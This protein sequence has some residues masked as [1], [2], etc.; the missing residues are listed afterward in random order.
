VADWDERYRRG[1]H[2]PHEPNPLLV[3]A[4]HNLAPGRA[5]DIACGAGR[6]ALFLA[7]QGWRVTAVD[8]SSVGVG[9]MRE[10][11]RA[12]NVDIDA[13]VSNLEGREFE[14][15]R[16]AFDLIA[17]FYY[18]Q[19]DLW[20]EIRDG[21]RAGGMVVAAIHLLNEDPEEEKGNRNFLLNAGELRAEFPGWEIVHYHET[22]MT[23][24]DAGIHHRRTAEIIARKQG[25]HNRSK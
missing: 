22:G 17:V 20:P 15:E 13:R 9:L 25:W 14:I 23:D 19:R 5:L 24:E 8:S 6:H 21:V 7:S 1:E 2:A 18:L 12:L 3:R 10:R 16:D 4:I 11:A